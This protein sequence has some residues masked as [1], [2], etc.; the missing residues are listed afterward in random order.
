MKISSFSIQDAILQQVEPFSIS[1]P[2]S[3]VD[4]F[5]NT[6]KSE[7][8]EFSFLNVDSKRVLDW[9]SNFGIFAQ[10]CFNQNASSVIS[11]EP[12]STIAIIE[13]DIAVTL[14]ESIK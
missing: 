2:K 14:F 11:I 12:N 13:V 1:I 7:K 9:G 8:Y 6:L 5:K 10:W 3:K 4:I